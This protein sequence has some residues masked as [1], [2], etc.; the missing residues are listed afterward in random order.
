MN[1]FMQLAIQQAE[2]ASLIG[3]VPIGA[4][5]T[6][7]GKFITSAKNQQIKQNNPLAHAEIIAINQSTFMV[8][9]LI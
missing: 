7:D 8:K 1:K 2:Q 9:Q 3:E 5:I 6:L 4:V